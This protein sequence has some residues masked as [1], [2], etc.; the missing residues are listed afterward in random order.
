MLDF[1]AMGMVLNEALTGYDIKKEIEEGVG[2]FYKAS[3]GSLYPALKKLADK[4]YLTMDEQPDS[5]RLKKYYKATEAGKTTFLE[6]L[7]SPFDENSSSDS[8]LARIYFFGKL[9]E[10]IRNRQLQEYELHYRQILRKLQ[11][12]EQRFSVSVEDDRD[13]FEIST[14]YLGLQHLQDSIRWLRHIREQQPLSNFI[15]EEKFH[16]DNNQY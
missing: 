9:P 1:I 10:D 2:N 3:Y 7:S 6:W 11:T 16:N 8:L 12:M 15:H 5:N 13:Y 14:L 4:G